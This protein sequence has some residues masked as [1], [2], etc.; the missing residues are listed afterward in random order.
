MILRVL[1]NTGI[2]MAFFDGLTAFY[3]ATDS[4]GRTLYFPWGRR[5]PGYITKSNEQV[6]RLR[7]SHK[8]ELLACC[9]LGIVIETVAS[10]NVWLFLLVV[11]AY[12]GWR[13]WRSLAETKNLEKSSA[14]IS[15]AE[16]SVDLSWSTLSAYAAGSI[17]F[18]G[19]S[20]WFLYKD[21]SYVLG[22]LGL[23]LFG[24]F[25]YQSGRL[26]AAR[27]LSSRPRE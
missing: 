4:S 18:A 20:F 14:E 25:A 17:L 24:Y 1:P 8:R 11:E 23:A 7:R 2:R 9:S 21:P 27:W 13:Y 19:L 26:L 22:Y 5:G 10:S 3:F 6:A 12:I 16:P 15:F